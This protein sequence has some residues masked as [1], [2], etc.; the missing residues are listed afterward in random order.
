MSDSLREPY[1]LRN[2]GSSVLH[3]LPEFAQIHVHWVGDACYLTISSSFV[4]FCFCLQSFASSEPFPMSQ[5]FTSDGQS[6]RASAS[7]TALPMNIQDWFPL[8]L[9]GL[10]SCNPRDSEES[11]PAPRFESNNSLVLSFLYD[12]T[13][14][15]IRNDWKNHSFDYMDLVSKVMSLLFNMLSSF[16]TAF[17]P[18]S[19]YL[20]ISWVQSLFTVILEPKKIKSVSASTFY[21]SICH[22]VMGLEVII[23]IIYIY[24]Y[25]FFSCWDSKQLFHSPVSPSSRGSLVPLHFLPLK[26]YH[27][28]FWGCWYAPWK[29]H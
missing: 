8:G 11:S 9:T 7:A 28:H 25:F 16:V 17:L 23:I 15:S 2:C 3:Y 1:G 26:W 14:T 20:L 19:K 29:V 22:Q 4:P 13:L 5:L 12:P 24:I 18:R 6:L 10:I 27:L 21:P